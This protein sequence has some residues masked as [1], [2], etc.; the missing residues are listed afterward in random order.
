MIKHTYLQ[1]LLLSIITIACKSG[2]DREAAPNTLQRIDMTTATEVDL[3]QFVEEVTC[4]P[5]QKVRDGAR[6]NW[7][8]VAYK[9]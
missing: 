5:L 4:F 6:G 2:N 3:D 7:K 1:I 9:D 8:L